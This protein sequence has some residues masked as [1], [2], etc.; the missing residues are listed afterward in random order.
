MSA[1]LILGAPAT[2]PADLS[3]PAILTIHP[4]GITT[5]PSTYVTPQPSSGLTVH[6]DTGREVRVE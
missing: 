5:V 4:L 2:P 1:D 3:I 6:R